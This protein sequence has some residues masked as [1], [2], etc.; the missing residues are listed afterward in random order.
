MRD[1]ALRFGILTESTSY[2]VQEPD[3]V[4][5]APPPMPRLEEARS[6]TGAAAFERAR[7]SA[8]FMDAKALQSADEVAAG[9]LGGMEPEVGREA[10]KQVGGRMFVLRDS[11]WTDI[12][13]PDRIPIPPW[14]PSALNISPWC[15]CCRS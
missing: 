5:N 11:V 4:A 8:K 9:G 10:P 15:E 2:L 3:R 14:P 1:L 12:G 6:Q 7:R 13:N